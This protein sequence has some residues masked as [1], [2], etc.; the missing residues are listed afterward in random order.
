MI[1]PA[2]GGLAGKLSEGLSNSL[3]PQ[4][5]GGLTLGAQ[6]A[7]NSA[8]LGGSGLEGTSA[9]TGTSGIEGAAG[10]EGAGGV[11]STGGGSS[12][13]GGELSEAISSLEGTQ[14]SADSAAQSLATGTAK[15][16]ESAVVTVEDAQMAM[17]LA[18]Q[19]RSKAVEAAQNIFQ[20]QV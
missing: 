7:G 11:G 5:T 15:D 4:T 14:L 13:F 8:R 10:V 20:T 6:A 19:L 18:S 2:V 1:V 12:S 17:D 3:S 16:P 9:P